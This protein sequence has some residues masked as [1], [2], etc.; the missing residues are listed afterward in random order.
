MRV[1]EF[2][3]GLFSI[4]SQTPRSKES[5]IVSVICVGGE[6]TLRSPL[7]GECSE[8]RGRQT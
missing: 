3:S 2:F 7:F 4:E 8:A 1:V 5:V 6:P